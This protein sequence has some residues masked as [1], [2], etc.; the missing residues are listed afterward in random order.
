[1][2]TQSCELSVV[3]PVFNSRSSLR[4]L[5]QE[6]ETQAN[7]VFSTNFEVIFVDDG[8]PDE[9]WEE[10]ARL[11][12][13]C[14][15]VRGI[16]LERNFTQ[17]NALLAGILHSRGKWIL[18]VDDDLQHP[19]D[20]LSAMVRLAEAG[21]PLVYGTNATQ[22][23]SGTARM[24]VTFSTKLMFKVCLGIPNAT[25]ISAFRLISGRFRAYAKS[26]Q[27][28]TI[29]IDAL[30]A[31]ARFIGVSHKVEF[32][33]R[34]YGSS[35]YSILKLAAHSIKTVVSFSTVPLQ[36]GT[37]LGVVV[38]IFSLVVL[39]YVVIRALIEPSPP[40]FPFLASIISFL[41][42]V[43]LV[44][45]GLQGLYLGAIHARHLGQPTFIITERVGNGDT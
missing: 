7:K 29:S 32:R 28:P 30:L 31:G 16:R 40:G 41:S 38:I 14:P 3:V 2:T 11:A 45:L 19:L 39:C 26:A 33:R 6:I 20:Q 34:R 44:I 12:E 15:H 37:L 5:L 1:M 36:L 25:E 35:N 18:T 10:I 13:L 8:S 22:P 9:S 27:G 21:H 24:L 4:E 42:G 23:I 43:Q 17:H